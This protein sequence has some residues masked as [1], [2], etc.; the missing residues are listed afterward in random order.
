MAIPLPSSYLSPRDAHRVVARA[1]IR[2]LW[3]KLGVRDLT[4][5]ADPG[6][7]RAMPSGALDD[8]EALAPELCYVTSQ[9]CSYWWDRW[10]VA[11]D[12]GTTVIQ[13]ADVAAGRG[14]R[15]LAAPFRDFARRFYLRGV[16]LVHDSIPLEVGQDSARPSLTTL[17]AN[18]T[19]FLFV[20]F[21]GKDQPQETDSQ[22]IAEERR[23]L[24]FRLKVI[25][26]N[27]RHEP[28]AQMGSPVADELAA[29][30]GP[31]AIIGD[32]EE[33]LMRWNTLHD[34]DPGMGRVKIGAHKAAQSWGR[35]N[36]LM[37]TLDIRVLVSIQIENEIQDLGNPQ[38]LAVQ[39]QQSG[40][41]DI[42]D[43]VKVGLR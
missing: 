23:H 11:P 30:P 29:D 3:L 1:L 41:T 28:T 15:W 40:V 14:G 4:A 42:G 33:Y 13:P 21:L 20:C 32:I 26:Q 43:K 24:D 39:L 17:C 16:D 36:R 27:W 2:Q 7:L 19:P 22:P 25:S 10:S 12:N 18:K 5:V 9:S 38:W 35:D 37:D 34:C 8:K 6:A 31:A